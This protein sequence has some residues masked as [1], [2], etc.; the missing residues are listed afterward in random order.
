MNR[1]EEIALHLE[2][3]DQSK[4]EFVLSLLSDFVFYEEKIKELRNY[5]QYI[6]NPKNPK[7]QKALP[8]HKI[9]KDYQAQK[10]DIAVKILRTLD[11]EVG[12]ESALMKALSEFND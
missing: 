7:Q 11:G 1:F 10:N 3:V 12:E 8:V 4:K 9:L 6:I 2:N 5:P